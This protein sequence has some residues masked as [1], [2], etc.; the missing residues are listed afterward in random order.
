MKYLP[1]LV[2]FLTVSVCQAAGWSF[3]PKLALTD[4]PR[5]GVFHHLDGAGRKHIAVSDDQVAV[6]WEDN[7]SGDPQIYM[8]RKSTKQGQFGRPV[9]VSSGQEAYEPAIAAIKGGRFAV[10]YEQDAGVFARLLTEQGIS[11]AI[12]LSD[13]AAAH[14]S[15]A[16]YGDEMMA[17]WREK[18][19][20]RYALKVA[21]LQVNNQTGLK[22]LSS[23]QVEP[24]LV[25]SA[26]L[27]PSITVN[28]STVCVT[29]EDRRAGHTR[30][31]YSV[32]DL[33]DVNFSVPAYLN[34][35]YSNRNE[36]DKGNGVTRVSIT[37]FG[38]GEVLAAWMDKRIGG[39]GYGIFAALGSEGGTDFGPNEKVHSQQGDKLP[40]YNPAVTGNKN[41]DFV[42]AWD[43]F[44]LGDSDIWLSFYNDN[45]EW[46]TDFSPVPASGAGEQTHASVALDDSG[47]LHLL[48]IDR[49]D[50]NSPSQ[51]WYSYGKQQN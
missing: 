45:S 17:V 19:Q 31:M 4:A 28:E 9:T 10:V 18:L 36:Y 3:E 6:V 41:G 21:R 5:S 23:Y 22:K 2:L 29:W 46:T 26:I 43:D 11:E 35:F 1:G 32:S 12:S 34:E 40:H 20:G 48:W 44:R 24:E 7:S 37:G 42:V 47:D 30:L 38:D 39:K 8:A 51:L 15:I 27:M 49:T 14:P 13:A 33:V 50:S 25:D 16:A